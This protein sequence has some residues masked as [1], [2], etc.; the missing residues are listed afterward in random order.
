MDDFLANGEAG[1]GAIRLIRKCHATI[2]G[3]AA[4]VEKSFQ[5]GRQKITDQGVK[6][7]ALTRVSEITPDGTIKF[8]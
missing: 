7:Y 1:T 2:A 8:L 6:V 3:F 5:P 4:L